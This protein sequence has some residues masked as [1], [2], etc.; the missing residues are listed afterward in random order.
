MIIGINFLFSDHKFQTL[1]CTSLPNWNKNTFNYCF[2]LCCRH[3]SFQG[4]CSVF[5]FSITKTFIREKQINNIK[6]ATTSCLLIER[7]RISRFLYANEYHYMLIY[8]KNRKFHGLLC[9]IRI[10]VDTSVKYT[11]GAC[12]T[13][14]N[15]N[16]KQ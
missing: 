2:S 7:F 8:R 6:N 3:Q 1:F 13:Y 12:G 16:F 4:S 10:F 14:R 5:R 15:S 9:K 11:F